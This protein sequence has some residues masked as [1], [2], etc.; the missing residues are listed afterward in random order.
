MSG[1]NRRRTSAGSF[2]MSRVLPISGIPRTCGGSRARRSRAWPSMILAGVSGWAGFARMIYENRRYRTRACRLGGAHRGWV[3]RATCSARST[4]FHRAWRSRSAIRFRATRSTR[5]NVRRRRRAKA[6][7]GAHRRVRWL[8]QAT[9]AACM[10]AIGSAIAS[11]QKTGS[12]AA[13]RITVARP[14][15][16]PASS[17]NAIQSPFGRGARRGRSG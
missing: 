10:P 12:P 16:T 15:A 8:H 9:S 11:P 17:P 13:C 2:A 1:N 14:A 5:R 6:R 7:C 4:A 3:H